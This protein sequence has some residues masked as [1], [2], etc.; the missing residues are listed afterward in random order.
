[1]TRRPEPGTSR[2]GRR[3]G[4]LLSTAAAL[5]GCTVLSRLLGLARDAATAW[6]LGAGPVADALTAAMRL[7]HILRRMLAEGSLSMSLTARL[8]GRDDA[9]EAAAVLR[10]LAWRLGAALL[11]A[12]V[13][14]A[15]L[16]QPLMR[17]LAP[18]LPP[19]G[20]ALAGELLRACLP[21]VPAAGLAGLCMAVLHAREHFLVPALSPVLFN[22]CVLTAA[23]LAVACGADMRQTA[24]ALAL[25]M[26]GGGC[27]QWLLQQAAAARLLRRSRPRRGGRSSAR[28]ALPSREAWRLLAQLPSGA[29]AA[30]A[31]QL[32]M[33]AAMWPASLA[34]EGNMAALY[35]AERLLELP[36]G[37]VG[38]CLGMAALPPL[39]RLAHAGRW[40]DFA[41][42]RDASLRWAVRLSLPAA[43]GLAAVSAPLVDCLLGHGAFDANAVRL[44]AWAVLAY[45]PCLPACAVSRCL[46]SACHA[47][48]RRRRAAMT[49]L[50]APLLT[51]AAGLL[52]TR[53]L[54]VPLRGAGAAAAASLALWV[55]TG[56][57]WRLGHR[58]APR[59]GRWRAL[60]FCVLQALVAG[61]V[62]LAASGVCLLTAALPAW[63]RLSLSIAAGLLIW[64]PA[65]L[66]VRDRD[67]CR[68]GRRLLRR[69]DDSRASL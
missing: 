52:L 60:R 24:L 6:L 55:Q 48:G 63:E 16:A 15:V 36:L 65:L 59:G 14:A 18:G 33:L 21:Y 29:L 46:L 41:L 39:S 62:G 43:A 27:A 13:L 23:L 49:G 61:L 45:V 56:L 11:A 12:C 40:R 57:L 26:S 37:L 5:G 42:L 3:G 31:P 64:P 32:A 38:A 4:G 25:G 22:I 28:A 54:A 9:D 68:L 66:L 2:A 44:T 1:M 58:D 69:N 19:A 8:A 17:L 51:L 30:A 50:L 53:E 34:G 47:V 20:A 35:Y 10:A 67:I 7:P